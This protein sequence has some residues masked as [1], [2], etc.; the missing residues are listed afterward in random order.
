M[1]HIRHSYDGTRRSG[2][3]WALDFFS[4]AGWFRGLSCAAVFCSL[5]AALLEGLG[6]AALLPVMNASLGGATALAGPLARLLPADRG[7]WVPVGLGAFLALAIAAV[8]SRFMADMLLLRLRTEIERRARE[9]MGYALLHMA[10]PAFLRMRLGDIAKAQIVEGLQMGVGTQLFVQS[11]GA[12]LACVAYLA[13]ALSISVEMTLY[14]LT[15]GLAVGVLYVVLG[16][17]ARRHADELSRIASSVS[18]RVTDI[19]QGLKF[20]RATGMTAQA[21]HQSSALYDAWRHSY[22][23]S[24]LYAITLRQGFEALGLIFIAAFLLA[25]LRGTSSTL[26]TAL[27]F[28]AVFYRLAPRLLAAQ[29]CLYQARTYHSWYVTWSTRLEIAEAARELPRASD[30][31]SFSSEIELRDVD[32]TYP[33]SAHPVLRD[34]S[35]TFNVGQASAIVGASGS[36]KTTLLD[37]LTGLLEPTSGAVYLDGKDLRSVDMQRWRTRIGLVQQEPLLMHGTVAENIAWGEAAPDVKRIREAAL[38]AG[39]LS[40][41]DALPE[42]MQ[43]IIGERGGRLS[44]GQRQRIALARSLYREPE[45]LILDEPTSALDA[46]SQRDV[47]AALSAIKGRCTIVI[48]THSREVAAFCDQVIS[49]SEGVVTSVEGLHSVGGCTRPLRPAPQHC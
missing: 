1:P 5:V 19:F 40:F 45:L 42:G 11:L 14:T 26:P 15:F 23:A 31:P 44:G 9:K 29:D 22:F 25:S 35:I 17:W 2:F 3:R 8:L 10:W 38:Q 43:T 24:Q 18:E 12:S 21:E 49:F 20:I 6:L 47:L 33:G 7:L 32:F 36:G 30:E 13:V 39:A 34:V 48:V 28:L 37:L 27:V 4:L 16:S 41:I 46:V